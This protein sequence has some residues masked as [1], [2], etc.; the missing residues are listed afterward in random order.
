M[1]VSIGE[2]ASRWDFFVSYT[3]VDRGWAE[4]VAWQLEHAGYRVFVQA[5]DFVPGSN[6]AVGMQQGVAGARRTIALLSAAYLRSVYGEAEWLAAQAADPLGFARKLLPIRLEDCPRPG[7]L[8]Q[9]VSIDL[10]GRPAEVARQHLLDTIGHAVAGRAKPAAE[11]VFPFRDPV[12][13]FPDPP[14]PV[15]ATPTRPSSSISPPARTL[16]A[17]SG[18][19]RPAPRPRAVPLPRLLEPPLTVAGEAWSVVFSP[20]GRTLASAESSAGSVRLWDVTDP[21]A[22]RPLGRPLTGHTNWVL[23]IRFS[24]DGTILACGCG[25]GGG[26]GS[27]QLWDMTNRTAHHPLGPPLTGQTTEAWSVVFSP[28]GTILASGSGRMD[29][30]GDDHNTVRLWD[31]TDRTAPRPLGPPLTGDAASVAFSPDGHTVAIGDGDNTV[32]LWDVTDPNAPYPVGPPLTGHADQV[33]ASVSVASVVFSPDGRTLASAGT[34]GLVRLWEV[35]DRTSSHRAG[36]PLTGHTGPV[37]EVVFSPD[38]RTLASAGNT[39]GTVRLWDVTDPSTPRPLGRPLTGHT[40]GVASVAFSPD[41]RTLAS[42]G[43]Y[44]GT[45]R[46]WALG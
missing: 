22:P 8:G 1:G 44:D 28:D 26:G 35:A 19:H 18:S 24:P 11:P 46:L 34:D 12:P 9:I 5:W 16:P 36:R 15:P 40:S 27:L 31:L 30:N 6:W 4:W 38:G 10:F 41:G 37:L 42:G 33:D 25:S 2:P 32:Q 29:G 17:P 20:D 23:S 43:S 39:D 3:A 45:V 13:A 7:L 14:R 21:S